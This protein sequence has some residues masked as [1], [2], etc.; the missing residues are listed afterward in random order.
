MPELVLVEN[1]EQVYDFIDRGFGATSDWVALGPSAMYALEME[2]I[3]YVIPED[4]YSKADLSDLCLRTHESVEYLC[5]RLDNEIF[6]KNSHL[7]DWMMKPFLFNIFHLTRIFDTLVSRIFMLR[8]LFKAYR[9]YTIFVHTDVRSDLNRSE[10]PFAD[11]ENIWAELLSLGGWGME[12]KFFP[13]PKMINGRFA[14]KQRV[15][16]IAFKMFKYSVKAFRRLARFIAEI[17]SVNTTS[18]GTL[19]YRGGEEW[20]LVIPHLRN[21]GWAVVPFRVNTVVPKD[22]SSSC[23]ASVIESDSMLMQL[24]EYAG[25][26]FYP[27]LK[28]RLQLIEISGNENLSVISRNM[29]AAVKRQKIKGVLCTASSD[30]RDNAINQAA[31][32]NNIPVINWQHGFACYNGRI[33]QMN[34]F[35]DIMS[36]SDLFVFGSDIEKGYNS[37]YDKFPAKVRSIGSVSLDRIKGLLAEKKPEFDD[38]SPVKSILYATTNYCQNNWYFGFSAEYNDRD[39][40]NDQL[41]IIRALKEI[42]KKFEEVSITIKLHPSY[43]YDDPPWIN[44][45]ALEERIKLI[46]NEES[47]TGLLFDHDAV[48]IDFPTTIILQSIAASKP[49]FALT[50]YVDLTDTVKKMAERR[51]VCQS[52]VRELLKSLEG[53]VAG[54]PYPAD[55]ADKEFF[56]THGVNIDDGQSLS[57]AL[58]GLEEIIN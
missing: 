6:I 24:F 49:I 28:W 2:K 25:V 41:F 15:Y 22:L 26:L 40:Y 57:R 50:R 37:Y 33:S 12:I 52:N 17:I 43:F 13:K 8:S 36:S 23:A 42:A 20:R 18:K 55:I 7:R 51:I 1:S 45:V 46:K 38:P 5:N 9:G 14:E 54:G 10:I 47:F 4:F 30:F 21:D 3:K 34:E 11:N 32:F 53:Y 39:F 44:E 31:R 35:K 48:L 56:E 16:I 58:C 19:I 29:R 27:L